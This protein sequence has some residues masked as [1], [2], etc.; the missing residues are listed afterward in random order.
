MKKQPLLKALKYAFIPSLVF[1]V[2]TLLTTLS[3]EKTY[4]FF[5][6]PDS[7]ITRLSVLLIEGFILYHLYTKYNKEEI[8]KNASNDKGITK[9]KEVGRYKDVYELFPNSNYNDTYTVFD[10]EHKDI[11]VIKRNFKL[12]I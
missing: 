1:I 4:Q 2:V 3:V 8:I 11:K 10:T 12:D 9:S 5:M 7:N 6:S